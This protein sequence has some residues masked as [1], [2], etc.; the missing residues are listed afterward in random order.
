M[1]DEKNYYHKNPLKKI[2]THRMP[3]DIDIF[4]DDEDDDLEDSKNT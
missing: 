3:S 2:S 1:S 4:L